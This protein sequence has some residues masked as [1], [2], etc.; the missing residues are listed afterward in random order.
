MLLMEDLVLKTVSII[1]HIN[2]YCDH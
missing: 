1:F 2:W